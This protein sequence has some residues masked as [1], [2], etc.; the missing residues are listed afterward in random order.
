MSPVRV[1][2]IE[3]AVCARFPLER[4]EDWDRCGLL[5]GDPDSLV[6]GVV[7][8]LDPTLSAIRA[9]AALGA[10]VLVTH[11]PAFLTP[12]QWLTPGRGA[13][14]VVFSA[15][16]SG[17]ALINAHTNLDR[18]AEAQTLIPSSLGLTPVKPVERSLQ[19]MAMVTVFVPEN[20]ALR[21]ANA[22]AGAGAGRIGDYERC[23]FTGDGLGAFTPPPDSSPRAG[24]PGVASVAPEKRVEMVAPVSRT[25]GVVAAAVAAHPYEEPLITVS[26]VRIARNAARLGMVCETAEKVPVTLAALVDRA[27]AVYAV[28]PRVWGDPE[29]QVTR[30][31]T[32][33]GSAG[34]LIADALAAGAQ[35]LVAGEVRYHDALDA[36]ESGLAIV[37]L[38]HDVTEWPLVGLLEVAVRSVPELD[39]RTVHVLPATAGWWTPKRSEERP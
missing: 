34:S 35:A 27:S 18:D 2:D 8:A 4:A 25:R 29:M 3:R 14:G 9:T 22:M 16:S 17:V 24:S 7:L 11:H 23:S 37:E 10:N 12:P 32:G 36:V 38:G 15:L 6:T 1:G 26:E 21:V 31:A 5:A 39:Q 28:T 30:V 13:A 33:T 19:P 20:A